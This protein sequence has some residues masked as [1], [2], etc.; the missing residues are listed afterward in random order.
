MSRC[1]RYLSVPNVPFVSVISHDASAFCGAQFMWV[2][3][4]NL[5]NDEGLVNGRSIEKYGAMSSFK[6]LLK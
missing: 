1:S 6:R 3:S 5:D 4:Y 2:I